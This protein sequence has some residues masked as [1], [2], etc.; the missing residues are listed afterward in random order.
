MLLRIMIFFPVFIQKEKDVDDARGRRGVPVGRHC[1]LGIALFTLS[2][3]FFEG[4]EY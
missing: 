1:C 4:E 3:A 2:F